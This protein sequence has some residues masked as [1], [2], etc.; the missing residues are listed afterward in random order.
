MKR[1]IST[2]ILFL[3]ALVVVGFSGCK[4]AS[5]VGTAT[6]P[7]LTFTQATNASLQAAHK[8]GTDIAAS[9]QNGSLSLTPVEKQAFDLF[10]TSL[11]A[12]DA[13]FIAY[14]NGSATQTQVTSSLANTTSLQTAAQTTLAGGD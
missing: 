3:S 10:V 14:T 9:V 7:T 1:Y 12:T 2:G 5:T 4:R 6:A 11:N 8:F 13:L